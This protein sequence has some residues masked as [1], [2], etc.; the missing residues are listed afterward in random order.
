MVQER[1]AALKKNDQYKS[2]FLKLCLNSV[3]GRLCMNRENQ[4]HY[5][6]LEIDSIDLSIERKKNNYVCEQEISSTL[7]RVEVK[8]DVVTL[9]IPNYAR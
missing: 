9:D 8:P 7:C 5:K 3:Y 4:K 1:R 2:S 6:L